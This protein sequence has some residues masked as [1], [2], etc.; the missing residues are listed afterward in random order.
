MKA[1]LMLDPERRDAQRA[2]VAERAEVLLESGDRLWVQMDESLAAR[3][4]EQGVQLQPQEGMDL[5]ELP[6]LVFDPA[7][8]EP[9]VPAALRAID[10]PYYIVQF[11]LP[12]EPEWLQAVQDLGAAFLGSVP[13]QGAFFAMTPEQ[14][15]AARS[16][17][18]V[19]W[20]GP[21]HPGYA[22][23]FEL[24]GQE[25]PFTATTLALAAPA[26]SL[27][28]PRPDG[29][30]RV[31]FFADVDR[32]AAAAAV[33]AAGATVVE[34]GADALLVNCSAAR[35]PALLQVAG[36]Q[37]VEPHREPGLNNQRSG[38]IMGANQVRNFG[39]LDFLV[40]LDGSGE[41][42]GVFDTGL[43]NGA[44]PTAHTDFNVAA[45]AASRVIRIDNLNPAAAGNAQD[46]NGHGTHVAGSIAGN[47]SSAPAPTAVSPLN[48]V[49]RGVAPGCQ[50]LMTSVNNFA[51]PAPAAPVPLSFSRHLAA[52]QNHY[53]AG[54]RVHSNSWGAQGPN[55]HT[56]VTGNLDRF[57]WQ[58][59]D[60]VLLFAAG[61]SEADLNNDGRLDQNFLGPQVTGKNA[62]VIGAS[63]NLTSV[64]G[65]ARNAQTR[66]S[67]CNR[68]G[69][70]GA[71][72]VRAAANVAT[73][74]S[75]SDNAQD[76]AMTSCRGRVK[77]PTRPK[78]RR[79][80]PDLV[81]PGTNILSTRSMAMPQGAKV[82]QSCPPIAN[83]PGI[84]NP[85]IAATAPAAS[86]YV[87]S[88]T[89]MATPLVAGACLLVRQFYRQRFAQLR[90]PELV[91]ALA[92]LLD[93]PCAIARGSRR[94]LA[95]VSRDVG[96]ARNDLVAALYDAEAAPDGAI[97]TLASGVGDHPAPAMALHS[98]VTLL[99]WRDGAGALK[100]AAFDA[101]LQP[102]AGFGAAG[103][104]TVAAS[105]RTE[106]ERRPGLAVHGND[107]AV[108]WFKPASDE[109]QFRR[110]HA[111]DG[112]ALDA[113]PLL[114]GTGMATSNHGFLL[115][116]GGHWA[117]VWA[118]SSG[119]ANGS[120][121]LRFIS[122]A[123]VAEAGPQ[124][125]VNQAA[126]C[127]APHMAWDPRQGRFAITFM[128]ELAAN[129]GINVLR[130]GADGLPFGAPL[131][132]VPLAAA[133]RRPRIDCHPDGGFVL[134]WE[135]ASD[136]A[137]DL[138]LSFL[139]N[140]GAAGS[141]HR[142][143]ISDTP[144][145]IAGFSAV[146][147]ANGV[148]P[149]WL[150]SDEANADVKGL[151]LLG[152]GKNGVFAAQ[153]GPG[154]P[155]LAQQF[156]VRQTLNTSPVLDRPAT[157]MAWAGGDFYLLRVSG[158]EL[159]PDLELVH[160]NADGMPDAGFGPQGA[161]RI[162][163]QFGYEALCLAWTGSLLAAGSSFGL[164]N[165]VYL[166]Q[167]DGRPVT[168][169]GT[170]GVLDL[171]EASAEP[172]HM[173][174]ASQGGQGNALRLFVAYG[175]H[176]A[177]RVHH[178]RYTVRN[179]R[180]VATVAP[181]E[182]A[183]I[184][185]T[186]KQGWFHL[187]GSESP[188]HVVAGWH[189]LVG[190]QSRVFVQRFRLD[191]SAQAGQPNAIPVTA[192]AGEARNLVI[193]PRPIQFAPAFPPGPTDQLN[194]LRREFGAAWQH[195]PVGGNWQIMFSRL[196]RNG[197]PSSTAG[198]FDVPVIVSAS[199]H[200]TEPQLVWHGD[201]YGLAWLQQ[202]TAPGSGHVLMFTVL[203]P[204]GQRPNLATPGLPALPAH[205]AVTTAGVDV[206]RFHLIWTGA[207][208]RVSW[209]EIDG[210]NLLHRQRGIALPRQASSARYDAPFQQ[211]SSA[212]IRATLIN[213]ATNLRNT[214]L[215]NVGNDVND[216]YGWGRVNLRQALA[217][218]QPV[219]FHVRD[220]ASVGAGRRVRYEFK[221]RRDTRLIRV[222]LAWTDPPG[223]DL[224]NHLHLRV[225]TPP[226]AP[227]G[228]RVFQGNTWQSAAGR[229]HLSAPV[230]F[231]LPPA[232][233]DIH[234]VQQVMLAAPPALPE[235]T[236]V[237][238][239]ICSGLNGG[240][241]GQF[242]GQPFALVFV[243]S[244][245]ELRTAATPSATP[246]QVY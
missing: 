85:Q 4:A 24:A 19:V 109:L 159:V 103:I 179:A 23:S 190:A 132:A 16:I 219:S 150:S 192:A 115:H 197:L 8:G 54:A 79:V 163:L 151:F 237:V 46:V 196:G 34:S 206:Q 12:P 124:V 174:I 185:G 239:V 207:S 101:A 215:P 187:L 204:L 131:R 52:F 90:R 36:V 130:T 21:Y 86:Y 164:A 245:P 157:A 116:N 203:D 220:D 56:N 104:V 170:Q 183:R 210:A 88:G 17:E 148:V 205:F 152:V 96:A 227:G 222:T 133:G 69:T 40:N 209:T 67:P 77:N 5:I 216:G 180:G 143:Q 202:A 166:L 87:I 223:P 93:P 212:L 168:L 186:S 66:S 91:Q 181:R 113:Q 44:V 10:T 184:A 57:A 72:A 243:G 189:A 134:L 61:N 74:F 1:V 218:A 176:S 214:A 43:D 229:T 65:D 81:A 68:F 92:E 3:F 55:V 22:M 7:L 50:L 82:A 127:G 64:D 246:A 45:S 33:T 213:G 100:L 108:V 233:E 138:W 225:T 18:S 105:V 102:V 42:V 97:V 238:E 178:L 25:E 112:T 95:W 156:Y 11:I 118:A 58:N 149:V 123:G 208:F 193:A 128:S 211:P 167:A 80:K 114:L 144:D 126:A 234:N 31:A 27:F 47:G 177:D 217:P 29:A 2:F 37:E 120:V 241:F 235:G 236:Y 110:F 6:A 84:P 165:R 226:F 26:P 200:A 60:A 195:Q 145:P 161:R 53:A 71:S 191:G 9:Q 198:E 38:L 20:V 39:N 30:L 232:F 188:T 162:D 83:P 49:P 76:I 221:V 70:L 48:S 244:G 51:L 230:P 169:F 201:G 173:Q 140:T 155:L 107:I 182:L 240:L 228:V 13:S 41:I 14:A 73:P 28:E 147:D 89:S 106:T 129:R 63:K 142:L 231:L 99:L 59:P 32:V 35:V 199:D 137:F 139:D 125:L 224:V 136:V 62:L 146:V 94:V 158:N 172:L 98:D 175:A 153:Q 15:Q 242:Q 160:T 194:S 111:G 121:Q 171:G 78:H 141:V 117:V 122:S 135:D 75:I 119:V 154:T